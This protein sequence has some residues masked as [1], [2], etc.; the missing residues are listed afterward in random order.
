MTAL[1]QIENLHCKLSNLTSLS[2]S[3]ELKATNHIHV[4]QSQAIEINQ[5]IESLTPVLKP[6]KVRGLAH[7]NIFDRLNQRNPL[8]ISLI[9]HKRLSIDTNKF[10][11]S[12]EGFFRIFKTVIRLRDLTN[13]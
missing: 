8:G 9:G 13:L 12:F 1:N 5:I 11:Q 10:G 2:R 7:Q 4:F 3:R 6:H